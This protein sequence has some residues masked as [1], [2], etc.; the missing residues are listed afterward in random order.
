MRFTDGV[1][2]VKNT[3]T[4][5]FLGYTKSMKTAISISDAIFEK[6]DHFA[7]RVQKSRSKIVSE[8]L[9]EYL[10]RHSPEEVTESMN[11]V[12]DTLESKPSSF[13]SS[14]SR[15]ILKQVEW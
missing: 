9:Q 3:C 13:V 1:L 11:Q 15:N 5:P 4:P 8:A 14:S 6:T 2:I 12:M 10:A 7:Q